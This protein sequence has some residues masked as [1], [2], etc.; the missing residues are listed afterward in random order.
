MSLINNLINCVNEYVNTDE[1]LFTIPE[2]I[3]KFLID[4]NKNIIYIHSFFL[5]AEFQNK[6]ILK[7]FLKYL[8]ENF[9]E[10]WFCQCNYVMGLILMTTKLDDKYFINK[11]TGEYYWIK[12]NPNYDFQKIKQIYDYIYPLKNVLKLDKNLF[13]KSVSTNYREFF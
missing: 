5:N 9:D 11:Y 13:Y 1:T 6:G 12:N 3:I 4:S 8:S 10:I 2:G 7:N